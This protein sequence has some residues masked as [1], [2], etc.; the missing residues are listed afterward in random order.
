VRY[1][2]KRNQAFILEGVFR[3]HSAILRRT[4]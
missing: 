1:P 2:A 4:I 3:A